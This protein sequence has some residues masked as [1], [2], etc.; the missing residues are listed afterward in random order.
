[1]DVPD[2]HPRKYAYFIRMS[3]MIT[4]G[5]VPA[6]SHSF[7]PYEKQIS[8]LWERSLLAGYLRIMGCFGKNRAVESRPSVNSQICRSMQ[9]VGLYLKYRLLAEGWYIFSAASRNRF[10]YYGIVGAFWSHCS[11]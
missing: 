9:I 11:L 3:R 1:M 10:V 5:R 8:N 6:E 7:A 4:W 2:L